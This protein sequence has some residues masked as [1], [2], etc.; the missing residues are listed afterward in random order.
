MTAKKFSWEP[1]DRGSLLLR[2]T[3]GDKDTT[4][5]IRKATKIE[6]LYE[7][8]SEIALIL[9]DDV[10]PIGWQSETGRIPQNPTRIVDPDSPEDAQDHWEAFLSNSHAVTEEESLQALAD[11]VA[12]VTLSG[13]GKWWKGDAEDLPLRIPGQKGPDDEG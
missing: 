8:F 7:T 11:K 5:K 13:E 1:L 3:A 9:G 2:I 12:G 6:D 4:W 10:Q